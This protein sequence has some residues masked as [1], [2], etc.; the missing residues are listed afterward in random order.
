MTDTDTHT[1]RGPVFRILRIAPWIGA[2]GLLLLPAVAM[3]FTD[4]VQWTAFDFVAAAVMLAIPLAIF[5]LAM[6]AKVSWAYRGGVAA[7]LGGG[8]LT[9]WANGAVGILGNEDNPVNLIFPGL[10]AIGLIGA[11]LV[12]FRSRGMAAV[13]FALAIL[14]LAIGVGAFIG[15]YQDAVFS[16]LFLAAWLISAALFRKAAGERATRAA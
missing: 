9:V 14:Q 10:L 3:R 2:G 12:N 8:F 16:G 13:M 15:G 11:F 7:A 5:E 4:Q 1:D 6:R